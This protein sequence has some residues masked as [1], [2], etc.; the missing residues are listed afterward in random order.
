MGQ[1][2][3]KRGRAVGR[4]KWRKKKGSV[5][6]CSLRCGEWERKK[7]ELKKMGPTTKMGRKTKRKREMRRKRRGKRG[8]GMGLKWVD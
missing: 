4:R 3:G 8:G 1:C 7:M 6:V 2:G 5:G